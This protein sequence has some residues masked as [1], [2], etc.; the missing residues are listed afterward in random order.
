MTVEI[1]LVF[2][3]LFI[4]IILFAFEIFPVDKIAIF[5]IVSL[6][7]FGLVEPEEAIAGFS[8]SATITVLF[9]MIIAIGLE[10]TGVISSLARYLKNLHILPFFLLL[11]AFML[12]TA[13]ISAFISTTAVVIVF[14]KIIS[15]LSKRFNLSRSKLLLPIS[16]AGIMGGSCTLM[17]TS[18]NLIVNSVSQNLG[19]ERFSFFE[20]SLY[21]AIFLGVGIVVI[22]ILSRWLP[23]DKVDSL[24]DEYSLSKFVT[25]VEIGS[26]SK[27]VGK[28]IEDTLFFENSEISLLKLTRDK[29]ITNAPGKYI[30]LREKDKLLVLCDIE[31][32]SELNEAEGLIIH[33]KDK[34]SK[35]KM[36]IEDASV[37]SDVEKE[38]EEDENEKLSL[39]ELLIL[40]GATLI[41]K[42][43]KQIRKE[44]IKNATPIAIQKRK[45]IRNTKERLIRKNIQQIRIKPGDRVLVQIPSENI[46]QLQS[47]ENVAILREHEPP[48]TSTPKKRILAFSILLTVIGLAA[49]GILSI[50]I[51][52]ALGV[53]LLLLTK[54]LELNDVYHRVNW[55]VIFL[56]A[57]MIPLGIAMHNTGADMWVSDRLLEFFKGQSNFVVI[58][59]IFLITMVLSGVVSNNATAI[60]MTPIAI[61]VASGFGLPLKP[62]ILAVLFGANFSFFT[63]MGYQT[64]TLIYGMGFYK[65][66]HFFIIGGI[67]SLILWILGTIMLSTL[68]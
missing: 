28:N 61:A 11:P 15:E 30:S 3:I 37:T 50:L 58:G 65:F 9:L 43:L 54:C 29:K 57:G 21:G 67:L 7:I 24:E 39:V 22:T 27:L 36:L 10:D 2:A 66:K 49:S 32:L 40:P 45:N 63:P 20:F 5:I 19:A 47:I 56:L 46:R 12:I 18:T 1:I 41:G 48:K 34:K 17:G 16:F 31:M 13:G 52:A 51:S 62:F 59:L 4:T 33:K 35:N 23:K 6:A 42:T 14:I 68:F 26:D 55:Q 44:T 64:N 8:N 38:E 60:I 25:T 53:S